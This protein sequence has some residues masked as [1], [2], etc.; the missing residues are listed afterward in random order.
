MT[1]PLDD[2]MVRMKNLHSRYCLPASV[3]TL[4]GALGEQQRGYDPDAL[5]RLMR[6][7]PGMR[8]ACTDTISQLAM[9][10]QKNQDPST[11]SECTELIKSCTEMLALASKS[12]HSDIVTALASMTPIA[13]L[14]SL[15]C[16]GSSRLVTLYGTGPSHELT[17]LLTI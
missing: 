7:S 12:I 8:K 5:G 11:I 1:P 2:Y 4:F 6:M 13:F 3:M 14:F 17:K 15:D 16:S 10:M 9:V